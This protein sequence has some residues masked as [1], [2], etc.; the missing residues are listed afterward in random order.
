MRNPLSAIL[1]SADSIV[2]ALD[3][4]EVTDLD[5][6]SILPL[7]VSDEI[8]DAV[9]TIILCAQHQKRIIDDV[10]TLSKLDASL[11]VISPDKVQPPILLEKALKMFNAEITRAGI[12]PEVVIEPTYATLNVDWMVLDP[13]RLLQVIINLLTNAIKFTQYCDERKITICL[14]ASYERPTGKHHGVNFIP[15]KH[16]RPA[17]SP[18]SEW[19]EGEDLFLQIAVTDTGHGLTEDEMKILFQRFSQASPK[20]YSQ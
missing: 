5:R 9:Q 8:I 18:L 17:N 15:T 16:T 6:T 10:L 13:S 20:T 2:S 1:Q 11:L 4:T 3:S 19:G 12:T 14:G 7:D